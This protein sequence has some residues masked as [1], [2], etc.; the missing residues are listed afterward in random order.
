VTNFLAQ[1]VVW[2]N[3]VAN[4]LGGAILT[5]IETLP[6]WLSATLVACVTGVLLLL[7]FK[8]T[9]NQ[10][11]IKQVRAD[12]KANMLALKLFKESASVALEA[13]GRILVGAF[14]L[15][16][17]ALVPILVMMVPVLLILGQLGLWYQAR[18]LHQGEE[19][20][21]KLKLG[22]EGDAPLP[23]VRLLSTDAVTVET[24]PVRVPSKHEVWWNIKA[25][26]KGYHRLSFQVG[27]QDYEKELAVGDG[28]MRVSMQRPGRQ[29]S[30]LLMHPSEKPFDPESAVQSIEII[31]PSRASW[32]SGT[33][34]WVIYWF[35]TSMVAALIV[36]RPLNVNV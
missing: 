16:I 27:D 19:A 5:P 7:I 31:Y 10:Q 22:G 30:D 24:G 25:Q 20:L 2:L 35:V 14:W 13:Q 8:Y 15:L 34:S 18:P 17:Y 21:V 3:A 23:D 32:T 4:T 26:M 6:G 11:A 9:S 36:R 33:D 28:F 29:W 12:I 1:I